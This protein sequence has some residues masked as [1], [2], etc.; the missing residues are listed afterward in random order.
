MNEHTPTYNLKAVIHETGLTPATLRAWERRYNLLKPQRSAGGHRLY[1]QNEIEM[2]KWLVARQDE[3]LSISHAMQLWQSL[4]KTSQAP[5]QQ[6]PTLRAAS[7]DG[8][9]LDELRRKWLA[10]CLAFDETTAEQVL[11]HA[12]AFAAPEA[13][14]FELLQKGLSELGELWYSGTVSVQQEHFAAALAM[15]RL[16]TLYAAAPLPTR[17]AR[18]LAAC[19][20]GETHEFSLLLLAFILRLRGYEV[21]Y[22]GANVPLS[23][24]DVTLQ[25]TAPRMVLSVSQTLHSTAALSEMANYVNSQGIP[26]AYGGGLFND[27]PALTGRIAGYYLGNELSAVPQTIEY[28]LA[29][30]AEM[31]RPQLLL[32]DYATALAKFSEKETLIISTVN[33]A[34]QNAGMEPGHVDEANTNFTRYISS[35]LALGDIH[36][37]DY[38]VGWLKGL[39]ENYG[40]SPTLAVHYFAAY[41]Q[42]V[43]KHLG[44]DASPILEWLEHFSPPRSP[45][46]QVLDT[47]IPQG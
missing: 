18:L 16:N 29:H 14:C 26:L 21:V 3:G 36:I 24:L 2:L 44:S 11:A 35:A 31:P 41:H 27:I 20:P 37:L 28:I 43:Q 30:P 17:P 12:F 42:A 5:L 15:R 22:L 46:L 19:P 39:L 23:R 8:V 7:A 25:K 6:I 33:S 40:L 13:V 10:A 9:T 47:E 32:P 4:E 1:T 45:G 34:L 38:S